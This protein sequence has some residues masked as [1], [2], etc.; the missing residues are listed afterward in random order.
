M[1]RPLLALLL[2]VAAPA[3]AEEPALLV[4]P[5]LGRP[6]AV[7][8]AGRVLE[9]AHGRHGPTAFRNARALTASNLVGARVEVRF[10]GRTGTAVSGHD[11]EF[12]VELAAA[13]GAPFP[14]GAQQV[15]VS[16]GRVTL[17]STVHVIPSDAPF[18]VVSDFDD[19]VAV[20][21][22]ESKR[23]VLAT[24]FLKDGETQPAVDG[25]ARFY[26]CLAAAGPSRPGFAFVSGSPIQLAP[27]IARFLEKNGFP[28]AALHLRNLGPDTL[29]GYKEPVLRK[30]AARFPQ[31]LVLVGDSG[32]KDPE[33]YGTLAKELPGRVRRIY[34]R[35][36]GPAGA[37]SRYE[38]A[39]LFAEPGAALR[40]AAAAGLTPAE[41][42]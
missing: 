24:T 3:A 30:L 1:R 25:M 35:R 42:R 11:G 16:T 2:A 20:T 36:A 13:P 32:E 41:C 7:W 37:P 26:R 29:S 6:D 28:P 21:H 9:E 40:D 12:E 14:A 23:R 34:I 10:L 38:G 4:P 8:I 22:V 31:P 27:R 18:I 15:E 5:S 19:T 33:I 39:L 17:T